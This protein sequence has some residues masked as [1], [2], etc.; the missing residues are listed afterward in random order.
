MHS[1]LI[2]RLVAV[3]LFS[4]FLF[5]SCKSRKVAMKGHPGELVKPQDFIA[6]KYAAMMGVDRNDIQN[7]RLYNFI[8]EWWGTPYR[9]GGLDKNG[10]DCSGLTFL[11]EQQVYGINIPRMTS[12]Q[13]N[14]IKR[15]Y[16]DEL[17]EGDLVFFDFDGKKFSHVGVYLQN[18]YVVHASSRRGVMVVKLRDPS[19]Y[20][21]FSRAGSIILQTGAA[22][23]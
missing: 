20:K 23:Y 6:E 13:I 10:V 11:L 4:A 8:E 1:K 9:F 14:V 3:V 17:Q 19:I 16:E 15:K 21:Y 22:N 5:T 7:G 12:Q 2:C 18:G